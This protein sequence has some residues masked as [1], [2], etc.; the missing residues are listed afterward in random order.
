MR[1]SGIWQNPPR[2]HPQITILN[3]FITDGLLEGVASDFV[4]RTELRLRKLN[5]RR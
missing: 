3:G 4:C 2:H 1:G 5:A